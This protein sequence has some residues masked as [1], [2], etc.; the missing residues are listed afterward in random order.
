MSKNLNPR[1]RVA[2]RAFDKNLKAYYRAAEKGDLDKAAKLW[3][4]VEPLALKCK[5]AAQEAR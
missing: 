4:N 1:Y 3:A 5:V 2:A